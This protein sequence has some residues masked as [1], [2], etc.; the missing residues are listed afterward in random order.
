MIKKVYKY[1]LEAIGRQTI[2]LPVL[3]QPLKVDTQ[4][5]GE[6]GGLYEKMNIVLWALVN[7]DPDVAKQDVVIRMIMTGEEIP[8]ADRLHHIG[9]ITLHPTGFLSNNGIVA[10]FFI[11]ADR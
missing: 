7:P 8:D 2:S 6:C 5:V 3:A 4:W 9:T 11:E 10:H 1:P